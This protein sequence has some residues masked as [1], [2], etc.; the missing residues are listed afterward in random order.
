M[1]EGS[2]APWRTLQTQ[3]TAS[4]WSETSPSPR[5]QQALG[6][7]TANPCPSVRAAPAGIDCVAARLWPQ[8]GTANASHAA[9]AICS[10][11][12]DSQA[13]KAGHTAQAQAGL[14]TA[15]SRRRHLSHLP[16]APSPCTKARQAFARH[17]AAVLASS[18]PAGRSCGSFCVVAGC[19]CCPGRPHHCKIVGDTARNA[20][21]AAAKA[22]LDVAQR[23]PRHPLPLWCAPCAALGCWCRA[24]PTAHTHPE[25]RIKQ[26][27]DQMEDAAGFQG[28]HSS[29][30]GYHLAGMAHAGRCSK[31]VATGS[32]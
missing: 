22:A 12:A 21:H 6:L 14:A 16:A 23:V 9:R 25:L 24:D 19:S 20:P 27:P 32:N 13:R 4:L 8:R 2:N 1:V 7:H 18:A 11:R 29:V 28:N 17:G 15:S 30:N 3:A 26:E 10:G 5:S 31:H